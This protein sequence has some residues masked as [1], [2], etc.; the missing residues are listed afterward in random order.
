MSYQQRNSFTHM[1][2]I[3]PR[4]QFHIFNGLT[5]NFG[6]NSLTPKSSWAVTHKAVFLL[7][8]FFFLPLIPFLLPSAEEEWLC[9]GGKEL[10]SPFSSCKRHP[11]LWD[12]H[13]LECVSTTV[14]QA[15]LRSARSNKPKLLSYPNLTMSFSFSFFLKTEPKKQKTPHWAAKKLLS[16]IY[17]AW[18]CVYTQHPS[19]WAGVYFNVSR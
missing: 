9:T 2:S 18:V 12:C 16:G 11:L 17:T 14:S 3:G 4:C 19:A 10:F 6:A 8:F 13:F 15:A 5:G 1:V 7:V